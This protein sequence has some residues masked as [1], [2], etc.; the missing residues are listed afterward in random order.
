MRSIGERGNQFDRVRRE[1]CRVTC[2]YR[3]VCWPV[4]QAPA[5]GER[6]EVATDQL[7]AVLNEMQF[8]SE[9]MSMVGGNTAI[10][11]VGKGG[12]KRRGRIGDRAACEAYQVMFVCA[13]HDMVGEQEGRAIADVRERMEKE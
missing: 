7:C 8:P 1:L 11:N 12:T 10:S 5:D 6:I 13:M 4:C 3:T 9:R 2:P